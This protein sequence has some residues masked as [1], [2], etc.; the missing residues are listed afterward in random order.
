MERSHH[1]VTFIEKQGVPIS[2]TTALQL[3]QSCSRRKDL[4][5]AQ[6]IY[7]IL[8]KDGLS[9]IPIIRNHIIRM[10]SECGSLISANDVFSKGTNQD[11]Y[12]WN[13]IISAHAKL[14]NVD[15]TFDMYNSMQQRLQAVSGYIFMCL[16]SM[17]WYWISGKRKGCT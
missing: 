15:S 8:S 4:V 1:N 9:L 11:S 10:F 14:G 16:E 5:S 6:E 2:Q 17:Q 3:I 7:S 13:A 12:T